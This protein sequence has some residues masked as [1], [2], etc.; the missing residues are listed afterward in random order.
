MPIST[1]VE[2]GCLVGYHP[3]TGAEVRV[4]LRE[5]MIEAGAD[6]D[7]DEL[8]AL[9]EIPGGETIV[10]ALEAYGSTVEIGGRIGK[11]IKKGLKKAVK[12][13]A[14]SK[15]VKGIAKVAAKVVPAPFNA[16]ILAAQG[17]AKLAKGL[18]SKNAK[19]KAKAKAIV[20]A[21]RA[22]AA[23]KITSKQLAAKAKKIGVSP[24]IATDAAAVKRVAN[25]AKKGNPKAKAALKLASDIVST[26]PIKQ[27]LALAAAAQAEAGDN[28][29][30]FI[31]QA[32][33]GQTYRTL[34]QSS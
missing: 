8:G 34:V 7:E 32:P 11:K 24:K 29:R 4:P 14:N 25:D 21:V 15:I 20:P 33:G 2:N 5:I 6:L 17:A 18:K 22:A 26:S 9:D 31:V 1:Y 13:V 10:G 23:G 30:A 3:G 27:Q 12:K 19:T 28:A 16:P